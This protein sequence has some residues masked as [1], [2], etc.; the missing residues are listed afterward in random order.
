M[1]SMSDQAKSRFG[2]RCPRL[3]R[4]SYYF[5]VTHF[6]FSNDWRRIL[7]H[8]SSWVPVQS[9]V[10]CKLRNVLDLKLI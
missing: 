2:D 8:V 1:K 5:I 6:F 7:V 10:L 3:I 4:A 9:V